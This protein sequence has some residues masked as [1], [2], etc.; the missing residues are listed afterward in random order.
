MQ[1]KPRQGNPGL[2]LRIWG[3]TAVADC[4]V[5]V[6]GAK[7][8]DCAGTQDKWRMMKEDRCILSEECGGK[9]GDKVDQ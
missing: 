3:Q 7:G 1:F 5:K 6:E 4:T 9:K 8:G 2:E